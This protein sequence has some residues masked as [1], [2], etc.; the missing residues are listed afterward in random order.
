MSWKAND[1]DVCSRNSI[2]KCQFCWVKKIFFPKTIK[3]RMK[4]VKL[5]HKKFCLRNISRLKF[6][7]SPSRWECYSSK[8]STKKKTEKIAFRV[9]GVRRFIQLFEKAMCQR[10]FARKIKTDIQTAKWLVLNVNIVP[11]ARYQ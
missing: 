5:C 1:F 4:K 9:Q 11:G 2:P 6:I 7:D 10:T 3:W 8:V